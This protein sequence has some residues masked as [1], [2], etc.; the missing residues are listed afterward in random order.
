VKST[1]LCIVG[2]LCFALAGQAW[3]QT[4]AGQKTAPFQSSA[5]NG[6]LK[7]KVG[8]RVEYVED[9]KW[10]KAIITEVRDDSANQ[11]NGTIYAPYRIHSLGYKDLGGHWV[12]CADFTDHRSQL[13]PAGSGPTEPVP[14]GDAGEANDAVLKAM[15]GATAAAPAQPGSGGAVPAKKYHCVFFVGDHLEDTAPLTITGNGTYSGGTYTFNS[16]SSTLTFHGGDY[17]GQRATYEMDGLP[18]LHI[19]GKSGRRVIDC[20]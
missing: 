12:C 6:Q 17:D 19:L 3:A 20:D 4:T 10:Y 9:G 7:Y 13:R 5:A 1:T 11:L 15:S 2:L 8:Q 14:G 16:A 18:K